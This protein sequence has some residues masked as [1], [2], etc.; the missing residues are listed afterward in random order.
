[1][2]S[3]HEHKKYFTMKY[4]LDETDLRILKILQENLGDFQ[5]FEVQVGSLQEFAREMCLVKDVPVPTVMA[6]GVLVEHL[7]AGQA[8]A[9]E[10]FYGCFLHFS[11][12]DNQIV[13]KQLFG[14]KK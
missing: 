11:R 3:I 14:G 13:F 10:D 4:K 12:Q 1:M 2:A 8:Q 7:L 6:M 9:R 5:D